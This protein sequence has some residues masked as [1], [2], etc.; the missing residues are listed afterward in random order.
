[1]SAARLVAVEDV[2]VAL[3]AAVAQREVD[4]AARDAALVH[5]LV[6]VLADSDVHGG[7]LLLSVG[8]IPAG[9]GRK[10]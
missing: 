10:T 2:L 1:M 9:S 7:A 8:G 3:D 6:G 4:E 5:A